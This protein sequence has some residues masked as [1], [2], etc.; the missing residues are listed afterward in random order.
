MINCVIK[1]RSYFTFSAGT[2]AADVRPSRKLAGRWPQL[3]AWDGDETIGTLSVQVSSVF[4]RV[5]N[6]ADSFGGHETPIL[7][8]P[9]YMQN[10]GFC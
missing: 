2:E 9:R 1:L 3:A 6:N 4:Q 7:S 10:G 5:G 8:L